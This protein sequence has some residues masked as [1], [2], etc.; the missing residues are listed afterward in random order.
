MLE[1]VWRKGSPPTFSW[2]CKLVQPLAR[3]EEE[4]SSKKQRRRRFLKKVKCCHM[5]QQSHFW[6]YIQTKLEFRKIHALLCSQQP[7][8][9]QLRPGNKLNVH[10]Q[11]NE[12]RTCGAY[13]WWGEPNTQWNRK[14]ETMPFAATWMDPEI[15]ILSAVSKKEKDKYHTIS[16]ICGI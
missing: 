5:I 16:P 9:Q 8:W 15:I 6:A 12:Y 4:D 3:T 13:A 11:I 2:E 10:Q 7:Y 14:S 1:R